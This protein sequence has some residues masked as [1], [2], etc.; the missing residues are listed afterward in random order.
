MSSRANALVKVSKPM[1]GQLEVTLGLIGFDGNCYFTSAA[2]EQRFGRTIAEID[3]I[4]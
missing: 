2:Y 1:N 3:F 4:K